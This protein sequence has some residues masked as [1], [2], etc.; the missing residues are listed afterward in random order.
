LWRRLTDRVVVAGS[1]IAMAPVVLNETGALVWDLLERSLTLD[2]LVSE[3]RLLRDG[4]ESLIRDDVVDLL[5]QLCDRE[6]VVTP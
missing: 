4:P 3:L 5:Q 1:S 6:V 2:E